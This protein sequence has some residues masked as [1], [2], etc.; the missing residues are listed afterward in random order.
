MKTTTE[1]S[2]VVRSMVDAGSCDKVVLVRSMMLV[3][4]I[5]EVRSM[6]EA[7]N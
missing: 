2:V 7:G 1:V 3:S 4:R 5:V 6:V